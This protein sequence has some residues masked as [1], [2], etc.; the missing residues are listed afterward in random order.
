M[1]GAMSDD[2][3]FRASILRRIEEEGLD[4]DD[5]RRDIFLA[6]KAERARLSQILTDVAN[7]HGGP[8]KSALE[9]VA[10]KVTEP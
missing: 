1:G 8:V 10:R 7:E 5:T 2:S 3:D 6:I 4:R 9:S